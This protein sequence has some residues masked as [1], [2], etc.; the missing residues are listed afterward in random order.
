MDAVT[1][2]ALILLMLAVGAALARA[3]LVSESAPDA[4]NQIVLYVCLPASVLQYAPRLGLDVAVVGVVLI[5][6][7]LLGASAV[8][9]WLAARAFGLR[10]EATAV[11]LLAVPLGN[12]S[13]LGYPLVEAL[14]GADALPYAVLYDQFGSFLILSTF[15][16]TVLA[17][18]AHGQAPSARQMMLR[19]LRFPPFL[20]LLFALTLMPAQPPQAVAQ[21]LARL[22]DALLPLVT[23]AIGMQ[24]K[25][26]LPRE[27]LA[28]LALGLCGKLI[29]LPALAWL[30]ASVLSLPRSMA[31]ATVLEAAMPTMITAMALASQSGLAPRLAAALVG[32]GIACALITLPLWAW[33]LR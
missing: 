13:F 3:R 24:L 20:A 27:D 7:L 25:L 32:Y 21:V 10:G 19:V 33:L 30:A 11:L 31:P 2:F 14:L 12:T 1:A 22:S 6:W 16:L 4:L 5:P 23:L 29:V 15:G 9:V 17:Y 28:P 26:R 8:L 18:Y